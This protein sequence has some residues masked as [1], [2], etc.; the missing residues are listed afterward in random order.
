MQGVSDTDR[1][2]GGSP[3]SLVLVGGGHAHIQVLRSFAREPLRDVRLVL[4]ADHPTA[5]YSGMV[6]AVVAGT[7]PREALEID[8]RPLARSA[9]AEL[10][11][12][13]ATG[14]DVHARR[15]AVSGRDAI[16][17]T[18]ASFDIGSRVAGLD[19]PGARDFAIATRPIGRLVAEAEALAARARASGRARVVVVG[20]GA[21]GVE[22][23]LALRARMT[24]EGARSAELSLVDAAPRVLGGHAPGVARRARRALDRQHVSLHL[25]APVIAVEH[26]R[27]LLEGGTVL[28]FDALVWAAGA[29]SE[30]LFLA[31]DVATDERGF[32]RVRPTLQLVDECDVFAA[33]DC[34]RFEPDLPKAGVYAVRQGPVLAHNLRAHLTG[35]PLQTY[36]PQRDFLALLNLG[37]GTALGTKWGVAFE[38]RWVLAWKHRI[39]RAFVRQFQ[40]P[41]F[42]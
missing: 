3:R 9:G 21:A 30:P 10:V 29:A 5:V 23:A 18:V 4:V 2:G 36:R 11:I 7:L 22:L 1:R 41:A 15:I 35:D 14:L 38:G 39:D 19:V 20:A 17:Y 26:D 25:G 8:L 28:P 12:A 6:P 27:I 24:L 34:A 16:P 13:A 42:Q 32:V 37:D 40:L 31:S 33:G